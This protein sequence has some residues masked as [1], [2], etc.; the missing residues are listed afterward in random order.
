MDLKALKCPNCGAAMNNPNNKELYCPYCSGRFI[1]EEQ[2]AAPPPVRPQYN[3]PPPSPPDS[4]VIFVRDKRPVPPKPKLNGCLTVILLVAF[5][6]IGLVYLFASLAR[7]AAWDKQ[8]GDTR[9]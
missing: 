4:K 7:R 8:F 3:T 5:W 2:P 1:R 9:R 6:P